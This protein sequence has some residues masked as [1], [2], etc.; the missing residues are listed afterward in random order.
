MTLPLQDEKKT[1]YGLEL[2]EQCRKLFTDGTSIKPWEFLSL[3]RFNYTEKQLKQAYRQLSL[4]FHPDRVP[5]DLKKTAEEA[6]KLVSQ[7]KEYM[8][9]GL[10]SASEKQRDVEAIRHNPFYKIYGDASFSASSSTSDEVRTASYFDEYGIFHSRKGMFKKKSYAEMSFIE[11]L[12]EADAGVS[13]IHEDI[14]IRLKQ[15]ILS[16]PALLAVGI[17]KD[18]DLP[19]RKILN[20]A[21]EKGTEEFIIWLLEQGADP[22][23]FPQAY[24]PDGYTDRIDIVFYPVVRQ[25]MQV[26]R[27]LFNRYGTCF[28]TNS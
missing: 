24:R 19:K 20:I 15:F 22:F 2:A 5:S 3:D 1:L 13:S 8:A 7:A 21:A 27:Y 23:T 16:N 11:L 26:L 10:K 17:N 9:Y 25:Q 28:F 14:V 12:A 18:K 6:F 4:C